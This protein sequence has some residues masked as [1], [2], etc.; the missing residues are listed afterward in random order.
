MRAINRKAA[1]KQKETRAINQRA[2]VKQKETKAINQKAAS[3]R[4]VISQKAANQRIVISQRAVQEKK[5][6][7]QRAAVPM[8]IPVIIQTKAQP[9]PQRIKHQKLQR[10]QVQR[11]LRKIQHKSL[12]TAMKKMV[13]KRE[14]F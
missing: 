8:K 6:N 14:S 11:I 7:R 4:A 13:Q 12:P 1:V 5:K 2:T 10:K 9:S 3:Q